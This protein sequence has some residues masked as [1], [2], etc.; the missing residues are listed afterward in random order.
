METGDLGHDDQVVG[1]IVEVAVPEMSNVPEEGNQL[2][3]REPGDPPLG[4]HTEPDIGDEEPVVPD[5]ISSDSDVD[6][7]LMDNL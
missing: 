6:E 4:G 5:Y 3:L 2:A 1:V 7:N